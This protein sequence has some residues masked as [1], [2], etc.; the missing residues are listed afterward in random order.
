VNTHE[1]NESRRSGREL[2]LALQAGADPA[3]VAVRLALNA[4][5]LCYGSTP[6]QLLQWLEGDDSYVHKSGGY[7]GGGMVG[8]LALRTATA[9]GNGR[10]RAAAARAGMAQWRPVE[11]G[12]LFV[13]NR[14][15]AIQGSRGWDDIWYPSVRM[16]ECDGMGIHLELQGWP[17]TVLRIPFADYWFVLFHKLAYD[18]VMMPPPPDDEPVQE[19]AGPPAGSPAGSA[20]GFAAGSAAGPPAGA[21]DD[22]DVELR[23]F[24]QQWD[25]R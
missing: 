17:R 15:F 8:L 16:S 11:Q 21:A 13:T 10:R 12:Q 20:A 18:T 9:I 3:P 4:G 22:P 1:I 25:V 19:N 23:E 2:A 7:Y 5:E 6:V 24:G 14:R